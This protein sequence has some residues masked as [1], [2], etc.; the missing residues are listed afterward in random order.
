MKCKHCGIEYH[1]CSSCDY[2]EDSWRNA[3][4]C[5]KECLNESVEIKTIKKEL[6]YL[7]KILTNKQRNIICDII[8]SDSCIQSIALNILED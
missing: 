8:N 5:T 7:K 1:C 4:Y 3:G 6:M 2:T